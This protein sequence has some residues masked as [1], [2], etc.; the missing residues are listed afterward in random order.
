MGIPS[1]AFVGKNMNGNLTT[2]WSKGC[3]I[4]IKHAMNYSVC[5]DLRIETG[6]TEEVEGNDG[7][8]EKEIPSVLWKILVSAIEDGNE[9]ILESLD[10]LF[11]RIMTMIPG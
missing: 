8:R 6:W 2:G 4:K 7:M 3:F 9:M 11:S 1:R 10:G 5:T